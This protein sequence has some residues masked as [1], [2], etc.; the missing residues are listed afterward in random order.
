MIS[1]TT[2]NVY[3]YPDASIQAACIFSD[4]AVLVRNANTTEPYFTL[5]KVDQP[6][7]EANKSRRLTA[8]GDVAHYLKQPALSS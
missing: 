6:A 1:Q 5:A 4:L 3:C 2:A 7:P 8:S